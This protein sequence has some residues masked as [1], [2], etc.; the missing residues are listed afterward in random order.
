MRLKK[1]MNE[2]DQR[3]YELMRKCISGFE[4]G[5]LDIRVLINSLRS[6]TNSLQA[7][8]NE[9]KNK[10]LQEWWILEEIYSIASSKEQDYLS[11]E[12]SDDIIDAVNNMKQL[13][14]QVTSNKAKV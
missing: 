1:K 13:L 7:P 3:Q 11:K 8:N 4:I 12:D 9:W 6:L 10:F 2:F 5:N 14:R